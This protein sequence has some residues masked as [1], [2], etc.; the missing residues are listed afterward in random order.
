MCSLEAGRKYLINPG[1]VGQPRD[2]N[3]QAAF[4]IYDQATQQVKLHRVDYDIAAAQEP[5][6]AAGLPPDMSLRLRLRV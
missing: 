5:M 2:G 6:M 4:A 3:P 1:A